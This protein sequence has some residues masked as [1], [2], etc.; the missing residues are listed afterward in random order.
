MEG[1]QVN[2]NRRTYQKKCTNRTLQ[3]SLGDVPMDANN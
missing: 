3:E 2:S 1:F